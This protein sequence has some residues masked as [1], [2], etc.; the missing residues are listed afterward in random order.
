MGRV[1]VTGCAGFIGSHVAE[2]LLEDGHEVVGADCL[3]AFYD[4]A[5]K[6]RALERL[7]DHDGFEQRRVDLASDPLDELL[8]GVEAVFHLAGQPGVRQSFDDPGPYV[9]NNVNAT[10]RLLAAGGRAPLGAFV[11]ASSSSIYGDGATTIDAG[12]LPT[13]VVPE[14]EETG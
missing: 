1:L 7:S 11:Y 5:Q 13:G 8:E 6:T 4:P 12:R 10:R 3:T 2:R 14:R 9:R